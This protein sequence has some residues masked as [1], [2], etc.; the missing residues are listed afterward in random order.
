MLNIKVA[1]AELNQIP[2]DWQGNFQRIAKAIEM[3]REE[4]VSILCLP[5]LCITGYGCEDAFASVGLRARAWDILN[6]ILP[7]TRDM[8]VSVGLPIAVQNAVYNATALLVDGAIAGFVCKQHL[9]NDGIHYEGR[10]FKAWPQDTKNYVAHP[11]KPGITAFPVGDLFFSI[12]GVKIGFEVCEDAWVEARPGTRL[13]K[14]GIDFILNPSASHFSFGKTHTRQRFVVEGSRAFGCTYIYANMRGNESGRAIYDGDS[15]IASNNQLVAAGNRFSFKDVGLV[16][17]T[18]DV[19]AT[20]LAQSRRGSYQPVLDLEKETMVSRSFR[21]PTL[22]PVFPKV[23]EPAWESNQHVKFEEFSRAVSLALFDYLRKSKMSGFVVSLSGGRDSAACIVLI[24]LMVK[25]GIKELGL[26]DFIA[27][28]PNSNLKDCKTPNDIVNQLLT[29]AYQGTANSSDTTLKAAAAVAEEVGAVHHVLDIE[30]LVAGYRQLIEQALGR[31]L[32]WAQD[33]TALQNIQARVR[34]P[35]IWMFANIQNA[36]LLATSNRNEA[37]VGYATMD[38]DTSGSL[39]PLA[40]IDKPF[41]C[42][43]LV[44]LE[45]VGANCGEFKFPALRAINSQKPTAE[46]REQDKH[47][48]DEDDLMPYPVLDACEIAFVQG[49]KTPI[50]VFETVK[51][52]FPQYSTTDFAI[53]IP[54]F[55]KMWS[56][57]QWKRE[58]YAPSFHLDDHGNDPK[59]SFRFPILSGG[60]EAEL[61]EFKDHIGVGNPD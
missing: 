59:T 47:Q 21:F 41:L 38:G 55:F 61:L 2:M 51:V 23:T 53:W 42:K 50:E 5:E 15:R 31:K 8:I 10:W 57:N 29:T 11:T 9:A 32:S 27:K 36:L 52:Q 19:E 12:G 26:E 56:R 4:K 24:S 18:V 7:L 60:F 13:A 34:S 14:H 16:V 17:Q 1:A 45:Y 6:N 48:T 20:R 22:P 43:W 49:M 39:S 37:A 35:G 28:L 33:D 30:P 3:A 44:W 40:G 54:R 58:R 46:L 25:Y